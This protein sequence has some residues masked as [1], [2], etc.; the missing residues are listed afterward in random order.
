MMHPQ[1]KK[2]TFHH[3]ISHVTATIERYSV[4]AEDLDTMTCFFVFQEIRECLRKTNH[5]V[6]ERLVSGQVVQSKSHQPD[7]DKSHQSGEEYLGVNT[8]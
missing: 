7:K 8:P 6:I 3:L 2:K 4:S 5:P 1:T